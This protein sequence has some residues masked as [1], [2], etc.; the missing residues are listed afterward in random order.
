MSTTWNSLPGTVHNIVVSAKAKPVHGSYLVNED[1]KAGSG[2]VDAQLQLR[3]PTHHAARV[4]LAQ[5]LGN[6]Q[7]PNPTA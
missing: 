4:W 3:C 5:R 7:L 2:G 6:Q 1:G